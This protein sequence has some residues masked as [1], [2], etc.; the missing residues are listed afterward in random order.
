MSTRRFR[1]IAKHAEPVFA[2]SLTAYSL[3]PALDIT[4]QQ[5]DLSGIILYELRPAPIYYSHPTSQTA[6]LRGLDH[7]EVCVS[8]LLD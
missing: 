4:S 5:W 8:K 1:R 6:M 3:L 7:C 2:L